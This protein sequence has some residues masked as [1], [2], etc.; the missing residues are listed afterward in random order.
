MKIQGDISVYHLINK[1]QRRYQIF[2]HAK[3]WLSLSQFRISVAGIL[4]VGGLF[5]AI[6]DGKLGNFRSLPWLS[7]AKDGSEKLYFVAGLQNL[8]NSCFLNVVLQAL[9]SCSCFLPFLQKII[10]EEDLL[11]KNM[12][13][14]VALVA[15]LEEL[16]IVR[17]GRMVLS[18]RRVMFAMNQ[19]IPNFNLT[20]Q[21][22]A[23]EAFLHLLS[24]LREEFLE[25]YVPH[26]SSLADVLA[27]PLDRISVIKTGEDQN[28]KKRWQ[29]H[30]LGPF[31]GILGSILTCKSCSFQLSMDF[32]FFHSLNL[33]PVLAG[34][35]TIMAGCS[36]EDCLKQFTIAEHI[37]NYHCNRCWHISAQ[38]Y[39]SSTAGNE[40]KIE[41]LRCCVEQDSC[42]CRNIFGKEALSWSDTFSRTL[43]Q[44]SIARCPKGH[45]SFPMILDLFPFT[46]DAVGVGLENMEKAMER[47]QVKH[48]ML[49]PHLNHFYTQFDR[50]VLQK[51]RGLAGDGISSEALV[52]DEVR[53]STYKPSFNSFS[54]ASEEPGPAHHELCPN[55]ELGSMHFESINKVNNNCRLAPS[56][57]YIYRL[58]SVV[59]HFGRA[60]SGHYTVYRR[61][62]A[63]LDSENCDGSSKPAFVN[64]FCISDSEVLSVSE[65]DVLAAE[66][67]LL[68]Y[69]RI[70]MPR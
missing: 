24:S 38:K 70:V 58:V 46:K 39:L 45:I 35:A 57:D 34:S 1:L 56:K 67:S 6:R 69:E 12:P 18:P 14:T 23:A 66:A 16:C 4:G 8:G 15:L 52:G 41:K 22:D 30:Y 7:E 13:L 3:G 33:L 68:F 60:G 21:Q 61:V 29:Q 10:E 49:M 26:Y 63:D 55:P 54:Q 28:E 53:Y 40:E 37:E 32:E 44:S 43:K 48:Q 17:D 36:V 47:M 5:L 59:E 64:W 65:K 31:D 62:S 9:A 20:S 2:Y 25:G 42:G 50:Q 19:Y 11:A 51:M 27:L